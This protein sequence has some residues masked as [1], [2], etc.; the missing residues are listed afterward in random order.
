MKIG[1]ELTTCSGWVGVLL[2]KVCEVDVLSWLNSNSSSRSTFSKF[3]TTHDQ[4]IYYIFIAFW[5][6]LHEIG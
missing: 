3:I 1:M 5:Q 2:P 6:K 4:S